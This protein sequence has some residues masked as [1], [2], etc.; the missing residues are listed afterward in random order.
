MC[1]TLL[2]WIFL[3][4]VASSP[5][6]GT[7][8]T[9]TASPAN[10]EG[11]NSSHKKTIARMICRGQDHNR[12]MK[13]VTS[14]N[15]WASADI[16]FT[17]SPTVDSLRVSLDTTNALKKI[18]RAAGREEEEKVQEVDNLVRATIILTIKNTIIRSAH[19]KVIFHS[20][21][22]QASCVGVENCKR[23][24]MSQKGSW[25]SNFLSS[26]FF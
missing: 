15:R 23:H 11:P 12:W 24:L 20:C 9:M 8:S 19:I 16:R 5:L 21:N 17:V 1:A 10:T 6:I 3:A 7:I 18:E 25:H 4:L 26:L 13:L 22:L 2:T 14:L